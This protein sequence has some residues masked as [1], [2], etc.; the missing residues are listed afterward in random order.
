MGRDWV[1]VALAATTRFV[2]DLRLGPR[3]LETAALLAASV[4]ACC[5]AGAGGGVAGAAMPALPLLLVDNHLPYPA[6][7]LQVFGVVHHRR[8]RTGR[9]RRKHKRLKPPPGLMAG[10]VQKVRDASGNLVKVK[11]KALFGRMKDIRRRIRDLRLGEGIN[12]AHVERLNGTLRC[13][14]ARLA[15]R[16]RSGSRRRQALAGAL[17]LWRDVYNWVRPHTSLGG[18][19]PCTPAMASGLAQEVWSVERY[20]DYPVH[21]SDLQRQIWAEEEENLLRSALEGQKRPKALPTS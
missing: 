16:T 11:T 6:A 20:V 10:V 2:I 1:H 3:T 8:R 12:T 9:G 19:T 14:Q 5:V 17:A 18:R 4:A 13:Q 15:R 7:I 21:V